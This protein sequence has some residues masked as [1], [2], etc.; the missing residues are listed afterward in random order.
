MHTHL[1]AIGAWSRREDG[2]DDFRWLM[3]ACSVL[4]ILTLFMG[5]KVCAL[6]GAGV[7]IWLGRFLCEVGGLLCGKGNDTRRGCCRRCGRVEG[8]SIVV[9]ADESQE[10]GGVMDGKMPA[11]H[12]VGETA[13]MSQENGSVKDGDMR[14]V[15]DV[16][17]T[18]SSWVS[19]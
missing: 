16:S 10:S 2:L 12:D 17:A 8:E 7:S 1:V 15:V 13:D 11:E 4:Y 9:I 19:L 14:E 3:L 6:W 18:E 5:E